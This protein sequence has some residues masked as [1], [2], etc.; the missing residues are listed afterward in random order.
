MASFKITWNA[1]SVGGSASI[2]GYDIVYAPLGGSSEIVQTG[3]ADTSYVINGLSDDDI[4]S[5]SVRVS[6]VGAEAPASAVVLSADPPVGWDISGASYLQSFSV[7]AQ[8]VNS[9]GLFISPD[10]LKMYTLG[11]GSSDAVIQ[12]DLSV[13]WDISTA[14]YVHGIS[15]AA[16][17]TVPLHIFFKPDGLKM[18]ILGTGTDSVFEYDLGVAWDVSTATYLHGFSLSYQDGGVSGIYIRPDGLKMYILSGT[19]DAVYEYMYSVTESADAV[20]EYDL[21]TAWDVSTATY[22]QNFGVSAQ[23]THPAHIFFK[24][25]G[26]KMYHAGNYLG[27]VYEYVL[28]TAWDIAT[29]SYSQSLS[30][31]SQDGSPSGPFFRPDG[32][33]MYVLGTSGDAVHEYNL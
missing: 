6:L 1:P 7:A 19:E 3:S 20:Y 2:S 30:V 25:D 24:P 11:Y 26:L 16:Q 4:Y 32:L 31:V 29:A 8:T 27:S 23:G 10:G 5:F 17:D 12:Y 22:L 18:Y 28:G 15:V 14:T 33:K 13:A 9:S 21:G